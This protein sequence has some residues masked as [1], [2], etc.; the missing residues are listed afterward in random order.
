MY[1]NVSLEI[2]KEKGL[3]TDLVGNFF[4]ILLLEEFHFG[5]G[6]VDKLLHFKI[7]T[8]SKT[9]FFDIWFNKKRF[10][11]YFTDSSNTNKYLK[12]TLLN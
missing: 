9:Y 2:F 11:E 7:Q 3:N 12:Y 4:D 6:Y 10:K 8:P 5:F 1:L